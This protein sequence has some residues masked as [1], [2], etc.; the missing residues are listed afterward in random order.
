[1][2]KLAQIVTL[3]IIVSLTGCAMGPDFKKPVVET[4][5]TF[6]FS[7]SESKEVVNLKWW[8][9]FDDPVLYSLVVT[10]L[11]DNKD[12]MIAASR[13]EEARAAL[14]FTKA[15]QYPRLDLEAGAKAGN[16][17]GVSRSSTTDKSAYIAPV[18]S[19]EI[20]FWGKYRRST[21]AAISELMA[22]E[23]SLRTVQISLISEVVSTYFLLLDY[24]QRLEI[25]EQTLDS[26]L[27]SLDI[28]QKRF[29]KGIIPEIDLNQAQIQKEIAAG[30]IP[31]FQRLIANTE[32]VLSIL[33]GKFPGEIK[34][35]RG[36]NQQAVPPDI[37]SGIP[38]NILERRPDIAEA[39]YLLEAQTARIGVAEALRFPSITLTGLFGAVSSELSSISTDGGIWSVGG[40]LF[41]PLFDFKKS[42]S[43]VE[44]EKERTQQALYRYENS[45]LFAFREVSDA[46]NE[47]QTYKI[48]ISA[49]E[50]KLKAAKNAA[51]L[52]KMR[53]DK[54]VTSYL[55][56]LETERTLFDVGL[57]LSELK[58]QFYNSYVRLYKALGGGWLTKAELEAEAQKK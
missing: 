26:R 49:V 39:M 2:K 43:R 11:T 16:F 57:E 7:D 36:L 4:P 50:R 42:L 5:N 12:A 25:S 32:N 20:D 55:E 33:M 53:Y 35:G 8:E 52:S 23:Y 19:W 14:G 48:Q 6:R 46:L 22:S 45:V 31:L 34:T 29:D 21:E 58:Q 44:I 47:I 24:Y 54:G 10:A 13:I 41:G 56:V 40:S 1:M 30:A 15:D 51:V 28:I 38:S 17:T 27:Y 3:M 9:L 18:L 37:P